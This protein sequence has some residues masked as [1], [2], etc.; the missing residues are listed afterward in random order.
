MRRLTLPALPGLLMQAA[1]SAASILFLILAASTFA[2]MLTL[3]GIPTGLGDVISGLGFGLASYLLA[4]VAVLVVLGMVLDSTSILLIMVPL[5]L[6]TVV[7]LGGD[8]IWFGVVMV[9]AVE[10]GLLTPPLGLSVYTIKSALNDQSISLAEIF[11]G[12]LPFTAIMLVVTV[13]L[14]YFPDI[15]LVLL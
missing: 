4:Y 5:A 1:E 2:V 14:V 12:S 3:S 6:P 8:L 11:R 15:A 7:T 13:A 9:I 10:I